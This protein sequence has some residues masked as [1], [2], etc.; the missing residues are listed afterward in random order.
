[1]TTPAQALQDLRAAA[2][3]GRLNRLCSTIGIDLVVV[4]G[5]VLDGPRAHDLDVAVLPHDPATF[6][7]VAC[8]TAFIDLLH[9][10]AVDVTDLS[11]SGVLVRSRALGAGEPLFEAS[12]GLFAREQMRAVPVAM[13]SGWLTDLELD[14]LAPR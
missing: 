1:M 11:R 10:D 13:E 8:T 7:P 5:S 3:D 9:L 6:D 4:F 2:E 12:P 14:L